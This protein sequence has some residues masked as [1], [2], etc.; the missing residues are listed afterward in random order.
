MINKKFTEHSNRGDR[1]RPIMTQ[2]SSEVLYKQN[3]LLILR[4]HTIGLNGKI[5]I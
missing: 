4:N 1:W 2:T 3:F 5:K